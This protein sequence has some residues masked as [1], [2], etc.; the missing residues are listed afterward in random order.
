L[1]VIPTPGRRA[2]RMRAGIHPKCVPEEIQS[3]KSSFARHDSITR[4]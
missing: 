3:T 1:R 2:A 4:L